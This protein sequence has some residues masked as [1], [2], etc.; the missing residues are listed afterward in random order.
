MTLTWTIKKS[1]IYY[2]YSM[3][4]I[5]SDGC[6][7]LLLFCFLINELKKQMELWMKPFKKKKKE[8]SLCIYTFFFIAIDAQGDNDQH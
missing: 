4:F 7:L 8:V 2:Y 6:T 1:T 3:V 5:I